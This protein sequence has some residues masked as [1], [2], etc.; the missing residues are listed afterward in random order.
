MQ[1]DVEK[2]RKQ[3]PALS[4]KESGKPRIYLDN[5]AGTQVPQNA[6]DRITKYLVETNA[7]H[8][9]AFRTSQE[10][11]QILAEAHKA[12]ADF[13]NAPSDKEIIFGA[14]MTTLTFA[15]S[16]SLGH[17]FNPGDEILVTR[18]DHD[19]NVAPWRMLAEDQ[20]LRIKWLPFNK[21]TFQF[22]PADLQALLTER[23]KL[24]AINYASNAIGTINEVKNMAR[25]AHE[26]GALVYVDAVQYAPHGP[27]DVQDLDCDFLV[28]SA[29]KFF[30]PHQ[31]IL[32][33]KYELLED[34]IAYKVRPADPDPP[35]KFE[36]GTQSH[37]GQAGTL[38]AIEY[39]EWIGKTMTETVSNEMDYKDGRKEYLHRAMSTIKAYEK[40][41]SKR[42]I[43]GLNTIPNLKIYGITN[44]NELNDRVPTV[45][46]T[47]EGMHPGEIS[48]RLARENIF[49]WDGDFYA[50]EVVN[51]L[52]LGEKG[53]LLR[54]GA[55]HY[56]SVE[57]IDKFL[58]ALAGI[59]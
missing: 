26:V 18:M 3:F 12:M 9:G 52:G 43:D 59:C 57:E 40:I 55:T 11:D 37:E 33:G 51:F 45:S 58:N 1:L 14:N 21:E 42:L 6:I 47:I 34:L 39:L 46:F 49:V 32:W 44:L 19:G 24:V 50:V 10:S 56:N 16:R 7:N 8:G 48:K 28:C 53:G 25:L 29:Y 23:V 20:G 54:V 5:P 22:D 38:G 4:I 15:I 41:L 17:R 31:G 35:G 36:T 30:G 2:I 27:I 13:L